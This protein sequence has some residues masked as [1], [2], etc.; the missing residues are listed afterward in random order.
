MS[1]MNNVFCHLSKVI[2]GIS[3]SYVSIIIKELAKN[4]IMNMQISS[5]GF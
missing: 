2:K 3:K 4:L 1:F 5:N